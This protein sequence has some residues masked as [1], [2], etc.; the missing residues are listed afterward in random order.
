MSDLAAKSSVACRGGVPALK[1]EELASLQR[2]VGGWNVIEGHHITK[3]FTFPNFRRALTLVNRLRELR[4]KQQHH[5]DMSLAW[6]K[7]GITTW[8]HKINGLTESDFI[9]AAKIDELYKP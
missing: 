9:L 4:E 8:T 7:V 2:Q 5:P 3:T 1:R 6:R